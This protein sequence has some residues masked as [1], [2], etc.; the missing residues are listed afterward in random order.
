MSFMR[1]G[2]ALLSIRHLNQVLQC[3]VV[4]NIIYRHRAHTKFDNEGYNTTLPM[5]GN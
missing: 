5:D 2:L 3:T 1:N 4:R